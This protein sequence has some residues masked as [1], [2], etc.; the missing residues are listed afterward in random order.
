MYTFIGNC[1]LD[2]VVG[3]PAKFKL[4]NVEMDCA[5][6]TVFNLTHCGCTRDVPC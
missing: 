1:T 4:D 3:F 2:T 6:G 5:P